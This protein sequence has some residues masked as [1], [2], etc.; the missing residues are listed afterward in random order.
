[1]HD[2]DTSPNVIGDFQYIN[3]ILSSDNWKGSIEED[4]LI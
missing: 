3:Q 1:M 4:C 2:G